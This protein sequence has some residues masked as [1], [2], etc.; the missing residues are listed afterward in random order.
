MLKI[1]DNTF[2]KIFCFLR[3]PAL[4]L[5]VVFIHNSL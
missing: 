4:V 3:L 1:V 2:H 5:I